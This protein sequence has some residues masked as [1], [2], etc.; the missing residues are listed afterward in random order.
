MSVENINAV[1]RFFD[2]AW[3]QGKLELIDELCA[4]RYIDH[5]P[6]LGDAD[7]E[8]LKARI[9]TYRAAF[10]DLEFT[11]EEIFAAGDRVVA[12]WSGVGTFENELMG[13]QPTGEKASPVNGIAISRFEDGKIIEGW[14]QWDTMRLMKNIGAVPEEAAA[15]AGS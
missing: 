11:I 2:E 6:L 13:Q 14:A 4:E 9:E 3:G 10:P 5:D 12:R 7:R 8:A 15:P 1:Q